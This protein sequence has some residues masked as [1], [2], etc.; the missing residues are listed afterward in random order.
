MNKKELLNHVYETYDLTAED[1][2]KH[3]Y[4]CGEDKLVEE[5]YLSKR[6]GRSSR[7]KSCESIQNKEKYLRNRHLP[8]VYYYPEMHYIGVTQNINRRI[9]EHK[10][11]DNFVGP[12]EILC[13]FEREVD[14]AMMEI[15]FHMRG[16]N[17]YRKL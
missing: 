10:S 12:C 13:Y 8:C 6:D 11:H 2:F 5:F 15:L 4:K 1:V 7:C 3:C 14:A 17:G 9:P 16:Y